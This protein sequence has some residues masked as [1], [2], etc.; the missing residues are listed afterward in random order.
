MAAR[1]RDVV[2]IGALAWLLAS[3]ISVSVAHAER[4]LIAGALAWDEPLD[5]APA[6]VQ[7]ALAILGQLEADRLP[8]RRPRA[9]E[10]W[11]RDV[12]RPWLERQQAQ[13]AAL[14]RALE[15]LLA[16]AEPRGRLF[17]ALITA[18]ALHAFAERVRAA[19]VPREVGADAA[20]LQVYR[21]ALEG[22]LRPTLEEERAALRACVELA[23]RVPA[24][25][26]VWRARCTAQLSQLDAELAPRPEP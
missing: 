21:D 13:M 23:P 10:P 5:R 26:A 24:P 15:P 11:A 18:S 22:S 3:G 17:A 4:V 8:R 7:Q 1:L 20:M 16:S 25:L 6:S 12:F 19:P 9:A 2:T 14:R